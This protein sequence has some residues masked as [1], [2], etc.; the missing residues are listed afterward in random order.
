MFA[1][2]ILQPRN[3]DLGCKPPTLIP[4]RVYML[5]KRLRAGNCRRIPERASAPLT[6]LGLQFRSGDNLL[7][8]RAV[9]PQNGTVVLKG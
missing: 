5:P 1:S 6:P 2:T 4:S 9:C 8:V 7:V 3:T